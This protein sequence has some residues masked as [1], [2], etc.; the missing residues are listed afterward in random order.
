MK[1]SCWTCKYVVEINGDMVCKLYPPNVTYKAKI[2]KDYITGEFNCP[3]DQVGRTGRFN[4]M[5]DEKHPSEY[6]KVKKEDWCWQYELKKIEEEF[7]DVNGRK[8]VRNK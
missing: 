4:Y 3:D 5:L 2:I 8:Y 1:K 7:I 6:P